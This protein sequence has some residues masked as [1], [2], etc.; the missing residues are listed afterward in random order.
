MKTEHLYR[1]IKLILLFHPK[2]RLHERKRVAIASHPIRFIRFR[3]FH[4]QGRNARHKTL[5]ARCKTHNVNKRL[6]HDSKQ[7]Y[8]ANG[9]SM[10]GCKNTMVM[11]SLSKTKRTFNL[12]LVQAE[13][14][15]N[16]SFSFIAKTNIPRR[17]LKRIGRRNHTKRINRERSDV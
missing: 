2:S 10:N 11:A 9:R 3:A 7:A 8:F 5:G 15:L 13:S 12:K 4:W 1:V 14:F 17:L 6:T 16:K